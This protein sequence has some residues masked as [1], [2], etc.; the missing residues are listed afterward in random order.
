MCVHPASW[1]ELRSC[2]EKCEFQDC[3]RNKEGRLYVFFE[4]KEDSLTQIRFV[5][6]SQDPS[7]DLKS[8]YHLTSSERIEKSL[9]EGTLNETKLTETPHADNPADRIKEI[10]QRTRF[11]PSTGDIYWTHALKC[12]PMKNNKEIN[13]DW[14]KSASLC[15]EY[16]KNELDLIPSKKLT[17]IA[18][19]GYALA[20]CLH[21]LDRQP[22]VDSQR[23]MKYITTP[24]I[25]K[26]FKCNDKEVSLFPFLHPS[27][28]KP[29]LARC[30]KDHRIEV[31][32]QQFADMIREIQ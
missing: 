1:G 30:D 10:F 16:F 7:V 3:L 2:V 23:I 26:P 6:V 32:E 28:R 8:K 18:F 21:V 12:L 9:R 11:D 19:G 15:V 20:M 14:E 22:L 5:A 25:E 17:I 27:Y 13:G 24:G 4:R 29:L 31:R